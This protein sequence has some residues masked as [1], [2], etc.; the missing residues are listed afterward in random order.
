[1]SLKLKLR[2]SVDMEINKITKNTF[3]IFIPTNNFLNIFFIQYI[4]DK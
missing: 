4:L 3:L 2:L 1:M